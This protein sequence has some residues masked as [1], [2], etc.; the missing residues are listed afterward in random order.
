ML[1]LSTYVEE[2]EHAFS[3][4]V[5]WHD[6]AC[7]TSNSR[8]ASDTELYSLAADN[9]LWSDLIFALDGHAEKM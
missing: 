7:T 6:V 4:H 5:V 3:E 1:S 9:R 8:S 2:P